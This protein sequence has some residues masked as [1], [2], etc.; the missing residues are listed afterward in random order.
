MRFYLDH[1]ACQ[2][3]WS[4][5][6]ELV[7]KDGLG[8]WTLMVAHKFN[9]GDEGG[10]MHIAAWKFSNGNQ[11]VRTHMAAW[12]FDIDCWPVAT[13]GMIVLNNCSILIIHTTSFPKLMPHALLAC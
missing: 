11:A 1:F 8:E 4:F 3:V 5:Y 9:N 13:H 6:T 2:V 10:R 7:E 12:E